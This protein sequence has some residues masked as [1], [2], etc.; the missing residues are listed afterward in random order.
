MDIWR[1]RL[2]L[3]PT[4]ATGIHLPTAPA[5]HS[6][7]LISRGFISSCVRWVFLF[8]S[9][10]YNLGLSI[11][12]WP[13]GRSSGWHP[14]NGLLSR[15]PGRWRRRNGGFIL[16]GG[17]GSLRKLR[18]GCRSLFITGWGEVAVNFGILLVWFY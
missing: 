10:I 18:S 14:L 13:R 5:R 17:G 2:P 7:A 11:R 8:L 4:G 1:R 15:S 6:K 16:P 9:P 3:R 12:R